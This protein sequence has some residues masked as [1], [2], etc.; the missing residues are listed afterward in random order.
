MAVKFFGCLFF[1]RYFSSL[2]FHVMNNI[3]FRK[4]LVIHGCLNSA[5]DVPNKINSYWL[6]ITVF[7]SISKTKTELFSKRILNLS[8][9]SWVDNFILWCMLQVY[10]EAEKW[11]GG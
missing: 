2:S 11:K 6:S 1:K 8:Y 5:F 10:I 9:L 3:L 7:D 4:R